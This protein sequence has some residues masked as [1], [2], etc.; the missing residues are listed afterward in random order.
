M[1]KPLFRSLREK[2]RR[3]YG[4]TKK[5]I[6]FIP[7][8][9]WRS[10][11]RAYPKEFEEEYAQNIAFLKDKLK[12]TD[13]ESVEN[14][15]KKLILFAGIPGSGKTTLAQIIKEKVPK[16]L[17]LRGHDV[18]DML[19]LYGKNV[20]KYKGRLKDRGFVYPDPWY[21]SYL[22]QEQLTRNCLQLG[23]NVVFDDHI[24]TIKNRLG[25]HEMAKQNG[26]KNVFI[27]INAPFETYM[28]REEDEE[29][30]D[31]KKFL[32]NFILQ[33]EDFSQDELKK[34]SKVIQVDGT[35]KINEIERMLLPQINKA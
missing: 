27:Q 12:F 20:E 3:D 14:S 17:L 1:E 10:K 5:T 26:A 2:I 7:F 4:F 32:A 25:Y 16:T 22:Y 21:I 28:E 30:E 33:S 29:G 6:N 34:Y 23:Y 15:N 18:V 9:D 35:S 13:L 8:E 11:L 19:E 24:R 31:K